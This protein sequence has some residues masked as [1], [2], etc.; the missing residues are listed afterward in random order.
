[1]KKFKILS[2]LLIIL[3]MTSLLP[4]AALA[5]DEPEISARAA[6]IAN[7]ATGEVYYSKNADATV[8]PASTT[9]LVTALI[10]AE[11]V[12]RGEIALSDVVTASDNCQYNLEPDSTN[13]EPAIVPGEE[14][15]VQDLMYC[16]MLVSANEACNILAEHVSGS[17]SAFVDRMNQRAQE[18]GCSGTHFANANGL[19]ESDHYTTAADFAVLTQ[20]ALR[21]PLVL[22]ICGTLTYSVAATNK[23]GARELTNTNSLINPD[24]SYYSEYA[25]GVKTGYF[26]NAGYCLVS[27]ADK[28]DIDVICV[29]MGAAEA[30]GNFSDTLTLYNWMFSNFENKPILST[31]ET[32]MPVAVSLG[33]EE[34]TGVR[35][36]TVVS[37]ILP[38]DYDMSHIQRHAILYHERDDEELIA[39]VNAGQVLGEVTVVEVDDNNQVVRTFGTSLLVA[40]STVEMSRM[41]YLRS[42]ISDLFK[43]PAVRRIVTIL[44]LLLAVYILLVFFYTV[45][46]VRH[47]HSVREAKRQR[48]ARRAA[49]EAEWL[50][51]PDDEE[52]AEPQIEYFEEPEQ[53]SGRSAQDDFFDSFFDDK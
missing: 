22:E 6:I 47:L 33:T 25:Y 49:E 8:Q 51:F 48:A 42:Q 4:T 3:L 46:R 27:A 13:A 19:E 23:T 28:D 9:K 32:L 34:S 39:P 16:M 18:L 36:D 41:N 26:S 37:A 14:M 5:V 24:S 12:D 43:T 31:T 7:T 35:A 40:T 2:V 21:H 1:M 10:V 17:V 11:A 38:N 53:I 50:E 20:E 44:I 45:Q 30:G 52:D 15:T 29:V